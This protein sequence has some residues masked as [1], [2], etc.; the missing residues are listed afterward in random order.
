MNFLK[1]DNEMSQLKNEGTKNT[2]LKKQEDE[3]CI[4]TFSKIMVNG[5]K[6]LGLLF[7]TV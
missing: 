2:N 6:F 4:L 7:K 5:I 3:N 1:M